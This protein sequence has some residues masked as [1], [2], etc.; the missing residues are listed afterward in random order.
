M[1]LPRHRFL[2]VLALGLCMVPALGVQGQG[3]P[4]NARRLGT[5]TTAAPR[6]MVAIPHPSQSQDSAS[7]V[8]VGQ[9][10][11][12][13]MGKVA[14]TDLQVIPDTV[15]N[16]ALVQFGYNKDAL[17][18][19]SNQ[20]T[21]AKNISARYLLGSTM[22][23]G[24]DGRYTVTARLSGVN[25]EAGVVQMVQQQPGEKL[26]AFGGRVAEAFQPAVDAAQDAKECIDQS[27]GK[28]EKAV[29][30][31]Q[32]AL[33]ASPNHGLAA[34]CLAQL[35]TSRNAA[36]TEVVQHLS[37]AAA[38]DPQSLKV[39]NSLAEQHEA[40]NDT[41]KVLE[42]F[43]EMLR[44]AP[45][46]QEMR[47]RIFKY[48]LRAGRPER[49]IQVAEEG[50]KVDPYNWG[51]WDLKSNA[52]LFLSNFPCAIDALEQAFAGDSTLADTLFYRKINI[53]A[54]QQ[55]DTVRLLKWS[56]KAVQKYP[57]DVELLGYLNQAFVINSQLDSSLVVTR[58]LM[59]VD[60]TTVGPALA[61]AQ[62]LAQA[63]R[64]GEAKPFIDFVTTK[65]DPQQK[66]QAAVILANAANGLIQTEPKDFKNAADLSRQCLGVAAASG[67]VAGSCNLILGVATLQLAGAMDSETEKKKSCELARQEND[68]VLESERALEAAKSVNEQ[69][70][71]Q[72]LGY[73]NQFKPRTASMIKAYCK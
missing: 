14:G 63:K 58:K 7:A 59:E 41:A 17:L 69:S 50:L 40:A 26:D 16:N 56:K 51:L 13:R 43:S 66:E 70:A 27:K 23:K 4:R 25:D 32:K 48:M 46:N 64:Y 3:I 68:L 8:L 31:A 20:L 29:E 2:I 30:A 47:E 53:A 34:L 49:A 73:V 18:A 11:R 67:R 37:A 36:R 22:S 38:G 52:C 5:P 12:K 45:T 71:T 35:A 61:A 9:G 19:P 54:A 72:M 44:V 33:R 28:P 1:T 60:P 6:V 21:L 57:N 62:G 10:I 65:G 42:A 15:M 24:A 55:P 39:W